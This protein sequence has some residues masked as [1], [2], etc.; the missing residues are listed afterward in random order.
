MIKFDNGELPSNLDEE[1]ELP[2][3]CRSGGNLVNEIFGREVSMED[4][5][6]LPPKQRFFHGK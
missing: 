4:V 1:I 3:C 5:P 2:R 6:T